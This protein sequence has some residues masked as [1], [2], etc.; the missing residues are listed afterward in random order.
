MKSKTRDGEEEI[1]KGK[2]LILKSHKASKLIG[3]DGGYNQ[4]GGI[5]L[6]DNLSFPLINRGGE[7]REI[8]QEMEC[9]FRMHPILSIVTY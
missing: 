5:G 7:C 3:I 1:Q 8:R 9:N 4:N 2:I 6:V